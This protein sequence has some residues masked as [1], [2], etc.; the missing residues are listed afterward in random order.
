MFDTH[1]NINTQIM[2]HM[3][4]KLTNLVE[5]FELDTENN[6][7]LSNDL[8]AE[9]TQL[10]RDMHLKPYMPMSLLKDSDS[11]YII[12]MVNEKLYYMDLLYGVEMQG[13]AINRNKTLYNKS[14]VLCIHVDSKRLINLN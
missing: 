14:T 10:I 7:K 3:K 5:M 12:N 8:I 1:D 9:L 4:P 13:E 2:R 6:G 11:V